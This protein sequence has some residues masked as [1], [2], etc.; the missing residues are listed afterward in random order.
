MSPNDTLAKL[1]LGASSKVQQTLDA[2]FQTC[3]EQEERGL[4][5]FS[6]ATIARLG[7]GRGI[8]KA[9]SLRN[10]SGEKYRAL[11][12][13]FA[14][15]SKGKKPVNPSKSDE[16]WIEEIPSPK[17]RLLTKIL[18]SDLK[19]AKQQLEEIIP[20]KLRVDVYDHKN[21]A[22]DAGQL[23]D[24]ERRALEYLI[25]PAFQ[26]KWNLTKGE[27]GEL[28]DANEAPLFKV[29]TLDAIRKALDHL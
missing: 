18:S 6:I 15:A 10:K 27:H 14:Q 12:E 19:K 13:S 7:K 23:S 20:P 5:D 26:K 16:S 9:Q 21:E 28:L 29:A 4:H 22:S 8:P 11:V 3:V 17:H 2:I 1:K 24:Q 25:S